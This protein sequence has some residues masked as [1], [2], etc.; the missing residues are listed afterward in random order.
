[1]HGFGAVE[2]CV[3][4]VLAFERLLLDGVRGV[5][6]AA[7]Q[8]LFFHDARVV[9]DVG[10]ARHAIHQLRE[11]RRRRRRIPVRPGDGDGR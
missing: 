9:L 7:Q 10:D 4:V 2:D 8:G 6:Q 11:V 5:D 3:G 1:M